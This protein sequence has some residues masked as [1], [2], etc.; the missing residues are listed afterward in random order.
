MCAK[1]LKVLTYS[2][3]E[4]KSV[5]ILADKKEQL[6]ELILKKVQLRCELCQN[7]VVEHCC[8]LF[9]MQ[10]SSTFTFYFDLGF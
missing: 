10:Q 2:T 9:P 7:S 1:S 8:G 4:L 3:W 5:K 6:A